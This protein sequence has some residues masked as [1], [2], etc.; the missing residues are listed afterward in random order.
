MDQTSLEQAEKLEQ[1]R[2]LQNGIPIRVVVI[3]YKGHSVDH[4]EDIEIVEGI[5]KNEM[6]TMK[7]RNQNGNQKEKNGKDGLD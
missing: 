3:P 4:P 2:L 5:L 6:R 1:L 7:E